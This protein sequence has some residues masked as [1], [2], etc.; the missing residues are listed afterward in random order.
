MG[1]HGQR[2]GALVVMVGQRLPRCVKAPSITTS[3]V[4][5][6]TAVDDGQEMRTQGRP[7]RVERLRRLPQRQEDLM[8]HGFGRFPPAQ[9]AGHGVDRRP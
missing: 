3:Y 7:V 1:T 2:G 8:G 5:N 9:A 6:G 4:R